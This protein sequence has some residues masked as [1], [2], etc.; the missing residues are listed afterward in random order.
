MKLMNVARFTTGLSVLTVL[1]AV[2]MAVAQAADPAAPPAAASG[3]SGIDTPAPVRSTPAD[4]NS[5][6]PASSAPAAHDAAAQQ[7]S[8]AASAATGGTHGTAAAAGAQGTPTQEAPAA[9]ARSGSGTDSIQLDTTEISGNREL[10]KLLYIVP[11][12]R[13]QIGKGPGRPPNSL[14]DEALMPVDRAVFERQNRYYAALQAS[15]QSA[16]SQPG[17]TAAA[18]AAGSPRDEK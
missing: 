18:S 10:P 6:A 3:A 16:A 2:T 12:Q 13:A 1:L 8:T 4:T 9:R 5:A 15:T 17:S 14:V 11:W 7:N